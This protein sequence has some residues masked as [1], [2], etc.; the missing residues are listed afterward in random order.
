MHSPPGSRQRDNRPRDA[1]KRTPRCGGVPPGVRRSTLSA[2]LCLMLAG[3]CAPAEPGRAVTIV[4]GNPYLGLRSPSD[5]PEVFAPGMVST[6]AAELSPAVSPDL[7]EIY[8]SRSESGRLVL[9][10]TTERGG[11]WSAPG[12]VAFGSPYS[13]DNVF[14][15]PD[16]R[17]AYYSSVRP[18]AGAGEPRK[19][20]DLW[21]VDRDGGAW[22]EPT[23]LSG[24]VNSNA[25][26]SV[27]TTGL[28]GNEF[29]P[30]VAL[31]GNLYFASAREG[32]RG[33]YDIYVME[34]T[35]NGYA[36]PRPVADDI[37]TE[38]M[39]NGPAIAPDERYLVFSSDRPQMHEGDYG[40]LYVSFRTADGTWS[41]P[42]K[43]GDEIN[44]EATDNT[45]ALSPDGKYL[46]F[47]S[48]RTGVFNVFW[49][50]ADVLRRL[51]P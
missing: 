18:I 48:K 30:A 24:P 45:P 28:T 19:D 6:G 2:M 50:R 5:T 36:N 37:N 8:F 21:V 31:S 32:G 11:A 51:A 43:L 1:P 40:D 17:R 23:H 12:L 3:A 20:Y 4:S 14:V 9:Y 47:A 38:F 7:R 29:H 27:R 41:E 49:V 44:S 10:V 15:T 22:G 16:N 39:E 33:S 35:P 26:E 42:V 34:K 46:F 13:E 25:G